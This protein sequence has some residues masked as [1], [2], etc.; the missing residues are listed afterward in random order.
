MFN[1]FY[2][3]VCGNT[4]GDSILSTFVKQNVSRYFSFLF[5]PLCN[6]DVGF[7]V[8]IGKREEERRGLSWYKDLNYK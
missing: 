5:S 6:D 1:V 7:G 8:K 4:D 2:Y 3:I